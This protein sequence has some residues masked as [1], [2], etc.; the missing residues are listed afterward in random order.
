MKHYVD[1]QPL[2]DACNREWKD[3]TPQEIVSIAANAIYW[4][5][6]NVAWAEKQLAAKCDGLERAARKIAA[7]SGKVLAESREQETKLVLEILRD[8]ITK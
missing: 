6:Y 3:E 5:G 7:R 1:L 4:R 8:E 2:K